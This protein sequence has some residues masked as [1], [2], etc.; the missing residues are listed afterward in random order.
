[1]SKDIKPKQ[2][3]GQTPQSRVRKGIVTAVLIGLAGG[4]AYAAYRYTGKTVVEIATA[5]VRKGDFTISVRTRGELR[6][7]NSV[8][9]T[10]PQV[11][12]PKI[13][14]LAECVCGTS[15]SRRRIRS[16]IGDVRRLGE[17]PSPSID[18]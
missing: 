18:F 16:L 15:L 14:K 12:S 8:I 7:N 4:G 9:L 17:D 13:I 10:A 1:M 2:R 3:L 5:R 11:P 6:S